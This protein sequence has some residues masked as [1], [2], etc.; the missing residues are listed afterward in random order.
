MKITKYI[1]P[2]PVKIQETIRTKTK[3]VEVKQ[4]KTFYRRKLNEQKRA[5]LEGFVEV[6]LG[7]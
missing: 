5:L 4:V 7:A 6:I 1:I 3:T 2:K